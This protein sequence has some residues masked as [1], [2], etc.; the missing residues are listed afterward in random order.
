MKKSVIYL[1]TGFILSISL[2]SCGSAQ[3]LSKDDNSKAAIETPPNVSSNKL[4]KS[5]QKN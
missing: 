1:L 5:R 3:N 2:L 4:S